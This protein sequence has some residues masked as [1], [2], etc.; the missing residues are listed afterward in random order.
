MNEKIVMEDSYN[1]GWLFFLTRHPSLSSNIYTYIL[2]NDKLIRLRIN[3]CED[4]DGGWL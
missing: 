3:E 4:C 2:N 1:L